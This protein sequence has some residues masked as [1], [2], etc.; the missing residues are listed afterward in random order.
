MLNQSINPHSLFQY[1]W[2]AVL[3]LWSS[4]NTGGRVVDRS[5]YCSSCVRRLTGDDGLRVALDADPWYCYFCEPREQSVT[6]LLSVRRDWR[7]RIINL[8][9]PNDT[10][11]VRRSPV[12]S[13]V[14]RGQNLEAEARAT[15][16]RPIS[17]DWGKGRG[18][19]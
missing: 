4:V 13:D 3:L 14:K 2:L 1:Y 16:P 7:D 15:R 18:Q 8:F 9:A 19:K 17:R 11:R 6:G 12:Y 5:V 10:P